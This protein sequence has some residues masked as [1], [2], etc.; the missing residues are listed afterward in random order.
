MPV[1]VKLVVPDVNTLYVILVDVIQTLNFSCLT[2]MLLQS[3][4]DW[5]NI[6]MRVRI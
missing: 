6:F 4:E 1:I 2:E 5:S 3:S